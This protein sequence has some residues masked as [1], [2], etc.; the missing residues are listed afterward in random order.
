[1]GH[2]LSRLE[3]CTEH[4]GTCDAQT[5]DFTHGTCESGQGQSLDSG[6]RAYITGPRLVLTVEFWMVL[7]GGS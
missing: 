7:Q 3:F 2:V 6:N 5:G 4:D 1:M